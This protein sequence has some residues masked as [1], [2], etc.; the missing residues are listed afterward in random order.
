MKLSENMFTVKQM[1]IQANQ[2]LW[3]IFILTINYVILYITLQEIF[4]I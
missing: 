3:L 4:L 2:K 1:N